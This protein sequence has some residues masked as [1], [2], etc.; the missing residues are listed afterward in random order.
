M[1]SRSFFGWPHLL[2]ASQN[3]KGLQSSHSGSEALVMQHDLHP[4]SIRQFS[5]LC[6]CSVFLLLSA[7]A[8]SNADKCPKIDSHETVALKFQMFSAYQTGFDGY[9]APCEIQCMGRDKCQQ[10]CQLKKGL[11]YLS[12]RFEELKVKKG[13]TSCASL[14]VA[15]LEQCQSAGPQCAQACGSGTVQVGSASTDTF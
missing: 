12:K 8:N 10:N 11:S 2:K 6:L 1:G 15:C 13:V 4:L 9:E 3:S 5:H 14:T 7:V